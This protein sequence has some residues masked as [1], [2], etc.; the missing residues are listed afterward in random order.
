[1]TDLTHSVEIGALALYVDEFSY[2]VNPP[3]CWGHVDQQTRDG[4]RKKARVVL[5]SVGY[6]TKGTS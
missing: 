4:Y 5:E 1:M 6:L 3:K 2:R